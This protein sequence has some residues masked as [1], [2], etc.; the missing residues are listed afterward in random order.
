MHCFAC[1]VVKCGIWRLPVFQELQ[2][3]NM[4]WFLLIFS[5]RAVRN[6][7]ETIPIYVCCGDMQNC[8]SQPMFV[9]W[10]D[11]VLTRGWSWIHC[12]PL[13][14]E[15][16]Q[17]GPPCLPFP[18][19]LIVRLFCFRLVLLMLPISTW[20]ALI[21]SRSWVCV[22]SRTRD[23]AKLGTGRVEKVADPA[24]FNQST[25]KSVSYAHTARVGKEEHS[26]NKSLLH[27]TS[28]G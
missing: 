9:S 1:K 21:D 28:K 26:K 13:M 27:L 16:G 4:E 22:G 25:G 23:V 14:A 10:E 17:P 12:A 15:T 6:A 2:I 8:N 20:I 11:E 7:H 24:I 3:N 5:E 18:L 19:L